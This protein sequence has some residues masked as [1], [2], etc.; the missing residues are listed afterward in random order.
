MFGA[1]GVPQSVQPPMFLVDCGIS[2]L[3]C[4]TIIP[5]A[6]CRFS[7]HSP[8]PNWVLSTPRLEWQVSVSE[9]DFHEHGHAWTHN[10]ACSTDIN[11]VRIQRK[12]VCLITGVF[13]NCGGYQGD[14]AWTR[15]NPPPSS[16]WS[17]C[18]TIRRPEESPTNLPD[19]FPDVS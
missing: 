7:G 9:A 16:H 17:Q 1:P 18:A 12:H 4:W 8:S 13:A 2:P 11:Q 6:L 10:C 5:N 3:G 19:R 15:G 14:S